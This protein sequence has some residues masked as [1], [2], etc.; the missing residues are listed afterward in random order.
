VGGIVSCV[1]VIA[2]KLEITVLVAFMP[3]ITWVSCDS[4]L[5]RMIDFKL[6]DLCSSSG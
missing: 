2:S 3:D 1:D 5:S 6:N 4:S